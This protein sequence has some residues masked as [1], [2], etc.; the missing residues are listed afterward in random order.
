MK[1][2][3]IFLAA[4]LLGF[5]AYAAAEDVRT[6]VWTADILK[7][8]HVEISVFPGH[9][10]ENRFKGNIIGFRVPL[11]RLSGFTGA[12]G[13]TQSPL[14]PPAAAIEFEGHC[15]DAQGAGHFV[16]TP[17]ADFLRDMAKLAYSDFR[18]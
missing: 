11:S 13:D 8:T 3:V 14:R 4:V 10:T 6:G 15:R 2:L 1:T 7:D 16:F 18:E 5:A 9:A 17:R 12:C